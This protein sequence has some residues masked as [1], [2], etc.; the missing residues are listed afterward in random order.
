MRWKLVLLLISV[1]LILLS[2]STFFLGFQFGYKAGATNLF[3]TL[4][5][6]SSGNCTSFFLTF[7]FSPASLPFR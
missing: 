2:V 5:N 6:R 4:I 3:S 1:G 7:Q